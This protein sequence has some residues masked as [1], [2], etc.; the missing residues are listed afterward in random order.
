MVVW[1]EHG[2]DPSPELKERMRG[3]LAA[4]PIKN[5]VKASGR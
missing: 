3:Y 2:A 1:R 5:L 4:W